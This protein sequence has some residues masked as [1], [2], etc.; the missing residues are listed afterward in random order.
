MIIAAA[1][2]ILKQ[3]ETKVVN[4]ARNSKGIS[5]SLSMEM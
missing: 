5:S 3:F 1:Q 4:S 2:E